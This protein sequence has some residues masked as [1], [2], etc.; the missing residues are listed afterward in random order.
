MA[1]LLTGGAG[2]IG[3]HVLKQ[4]LEKTEE[5][6]VVVDNLSTGNQACIDALLEIRDF[7]FAKID[8]DNLEMLEMLIE[9]FEVTDVLHFAASIVVSE[10]MQNPLKYYKNNT[11]KTTG[12]IELCVNFGVKRFVFS[13]TAAV[14]GEP[15]TNPVDETVLLAPINPYGRSKLMSETVLRDA[16]NAH[17]AF[18][19]VILRYFN[20]AGVAGDGSIGQSFPDATHLIKVAA[21]TALGARDALAVFGTDYPTKDGTCERDYIH[22]EDLADAH[23]KALEYLKTHP[24]DTFNVGYGHGFSV[25]EVI[26]TMQRVSGVDFKVEMAPR[27]EGDPAILVASS[28]KIKTRMGWEP[29]CDDLE[30]ICKT[31]LAWEKKLH[32]N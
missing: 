24:S 13:S 3:S 7:H 20:V 14:Y 10:S 23:L 1:I 11:A 26:K 12:L 5:N 31:A 19:H 8:L 2:Y 4:L 25:R 18:K 6:I 17:P 32:E 9:R 16:S 27:R 15:A 30:H 22:V 28:T 29:Q 21:Q